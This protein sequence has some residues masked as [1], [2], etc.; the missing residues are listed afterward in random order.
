MSRYLWLLGLACGVVLAD[1]PAPAQPA[2]FVGTYWANL[3]GDRH[4][5]ALWIDAL[6]QA[7]ANTFTARGRF[8]IACA[9]FQP[10][11]IQGKR[12]ALGWRLE[13]VLGPKVTVSVNGDPKR[14]QGDYRGEFGT[15][16]LTL[17][18]GDVATTCPEAAAAVDDVGSQ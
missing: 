13:F 1:A 18:R 5:R 3:H 11:T 8:G 9:G 15:G 14:L 10:I 7:G 4:T 2:D 6:N 16:V 17:D 12:E